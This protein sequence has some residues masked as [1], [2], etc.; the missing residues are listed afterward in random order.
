[1][2]AEAEAKEMQMKGY[3]YVQESQRQIGLETVKGGVVKEGSG[4]G[5]AGSAIG[6]VVGLGVTLGAIGGVM[7]MAKEAITPIINTST[8]MGKVA[9]GIANTNPQP[10]TPTGWNCSC[11][12]QGIKGNFCSSCGTKKPETPQGWSCIKCNTPND[13]GNF[14]S[15]C[16]EKKAIETT[17]DCACGEKSIKGN[18]CSNCGNKKGV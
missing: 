10:I 16:G 2:Q 18:F 4:G 13:K 17:W 8:D 7:G 9:S 3:T 12:E 6:D 14:C 15:S 11:G 1:L 5:G